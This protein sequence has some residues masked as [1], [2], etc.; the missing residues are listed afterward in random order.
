MVGALM[1][2]ILFEILLVFFSRRKIRTDEFPMPAPSEKAD[3][4]YEEIL[5]T[6][7]GQ[8]G[9]I[10]TLLFAANRLDEMPVT[11]PVNVA[12]R[13]AQTSTCLLIDLDT[14]RNAIARVF[15]LDAGQMNETSKVRA[16]PTQ[17]KNLCVWPAKNF[18]LLKQTNLRAVLD[19]ALK[20]FTY[21]L[22]YAPYLTALPDRRQIAACAK[23]AVVCDGTDASPL[24][25]L[26]EQCN[27]KIVKEVKRETPTG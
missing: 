10:R 7:T 24:T 4:P 25:Q 16:C 8:N 1:L 19:A 13:L 23:Q 9:R 11:I 21:V 2:V 14:K 17:V 15:D 20:K 3:I 26:L 22:I 27:C 12:I 6:L 18:E 5:H